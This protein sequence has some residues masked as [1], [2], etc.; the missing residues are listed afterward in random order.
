VKGPMETQKDTHFLQCITTGVVFGVEANASDPL[1]I[2]ESLTMANL[3]RNDP[4]GRC[5]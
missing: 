5:Q 3:T 1:S 2:K 4:L